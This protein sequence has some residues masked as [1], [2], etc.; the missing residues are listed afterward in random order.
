MSHFDGETLRGGCHFK[1]SKVSL[2]YNHSNENA[3]KTLV[4]KFL[5]WEKPYYEKVVLYL[6]KLFGSLGKIVK[7]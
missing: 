6:K 7:M 5:F 3:P 1:V 2:Q 4:V